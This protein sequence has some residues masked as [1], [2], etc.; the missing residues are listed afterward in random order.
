MAKII[1]AWEYGSGMGHVSLMK[2]LLARLVAL[3]HEVTC[4]FRDIS[5][6]KP[7]WE[8][9]PYTVKQAPYLNLKKSL[10]GKTIHTLAD[11]FAYTE[12]SDL[13]R[14]CKLAD[15]WQ[16]IMQEEKPDLIICEFAFTLSLTMLGRCPIITL[17]SGYTLPPPGRSLPNVRPSVDVV[18]PLSANHETLAL[19]TFNTIRE[20]VKLPPLGYL[21]DVFGGVASFVCTFPEIDCYAKYRSSPAIG[22]L[23][24]RPPE[25]II[26]PKDKLRRGYFYLNGQDKRLIDLLEQIK[27][28]GQMCEGF[29]R[30]LQDEDRERLK[31]PNFLVHDAPQHMEEVLRRSTLLIHH[32]GIGSTEM[33][34]IHGVPQMILSRHLEQRVTGECLS[35]FL[36][37]GHNVHTS[38]FGN[39]SL[40]YKTLLQAFQTPQFGIA[41]YK[42]AKQLAVRYDLDPCDQ[43]V[44]A[45]E[46]VLS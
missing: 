24:A 16:K 37:V 26:H 28:T 29:I 12:L 20:H 5:V 43:V 33:A 30:E 19:L 4:Y 11:I 31:A 27:L 23:N 21:S 6:T 41:A 44:E 18:N 15:I 17:G 35:H 13:A 45:V 10:E 38:N 1:V 3:G 46:Q 2:P 34:L 9:Q 7:I 14:L 32:G 42:L 36:H 8:N 39:Q 22:S 40:L 25:E